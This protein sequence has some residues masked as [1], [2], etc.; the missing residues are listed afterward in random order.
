LAGH[1]GI[2]VSAP[3]SR[4]KGIRRWWAPGFVAADL[5]SFMLE[6]GHKGV[7][8]TV[9]VFGGRGGCFRSVTAAFRA[10]ILDY[11]YIKVW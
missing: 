8:V 3:T 11:Q 2:K 5:K 6:S 10:K 9:Q 7:I 4:L 1:G